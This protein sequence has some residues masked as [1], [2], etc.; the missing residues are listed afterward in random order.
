MLSRIPDHLGL[1]LPNPPD[2]L[3]A[4]ENPAQATLSGADTYQRA[5]SSS[6]A[7]TTTPSLNK[8]AVRGHFQV[9]T[10][11]TEYLRPKAVNTFCLSD[12]PY[13]PPHRRRL[14]NPS[15]NSSPS[16]PPSAS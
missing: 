1:L 15:T 11:P 2:S 4:E 12:T 3:A 6:E 13:I 5:N 7:S 16:Q 14:Y 10:S 8:D 9:P